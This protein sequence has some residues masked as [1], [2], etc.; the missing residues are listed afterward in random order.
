MRPRAFLSAMAGGVFARPLALVLLPLLA[1]LSFSA[2]GASDPF[3]DEFDE[4]PW[5]EIEVR[6]PAFP[7]DEDLIPFRVG[8]VRDRQF[9]VDG[10]SISIGSD[11]VIRFTVMVIS[12]SGARNISYEGMRCATGE[13]RLYAFGRSDQTWSKARNNNWIKIKGD[14]NQYPVAL[15]VDYFCSIGERTIMS[16]GDAVRVLRYG[17]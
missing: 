7:K 4:K 3:D 17:R 8:A 6:L 14:G 10:A 12:P 9:L 16:P 15:F 11:D 5:A 2:Y 13:R 1:F